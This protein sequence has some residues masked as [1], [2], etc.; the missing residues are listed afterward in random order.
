M[1]YNSRQGKRENMK[2]S[3][4]IACL[5]LVGCGNGNVVD[6]PRD[7]DAGVDVDSGFDV[8][9]GP[10]EPTYSEALIIL[11]TPKGGSTAEIDCDFD[12]TADD[13]GLTSEL[14]EIHTQG[15]YDIVAN[16]V[17][18]ISD[19]IEGRAWLSPASTYSGVP[20][21]VA[22]KS[23]PSG[24]AH[25]SYEFDCAEDDW[26][27][28]GPYESPGF[29]N[30]AYVTPNKCYM[31]YD[32]QTGEFHLEPNHHWTLEYETVTPYLTPTNYTSHPYTICR[33][34]FDEAGPQSELDATVSMVFGEDVAGITPIDLLL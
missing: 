21:N 9:A 4:I 28:E 8:D 15:D 10:P 17:T 11:N 24:Y 32:E 31:S 2:V 14:A 1:C 25:L 13:R 6:D 18:G 22:T 16:L 7:V 27:I 5:I 12:D 29:I 33:V 30:L 3:S 23:V 34:Q 19:E 26:N 20:V